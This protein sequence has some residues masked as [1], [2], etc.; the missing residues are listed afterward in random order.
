MK[1]VLERMGKLTKMSCIQTI[2]ISKEMKQKNKKY[3]MSKYNK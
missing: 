1:P 3:G 2:R